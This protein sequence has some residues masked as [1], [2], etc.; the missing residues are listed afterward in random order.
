SYAVTFTATNTLSGS[1]STA[2]TV[3][4]QN[5][6]PIVTAPATASVN[7]GSLLT[8]VVSATDADGDDVTLSA[9]ILPLGAS[10]TDGG[11]GSNTGTFNW[12]PGFNQAGPYSVTFNGSDGNGGSGSA[13]TSITVNNVNRAPTANANGPY[14]GVIGINVAFSSAGSSDPD[15]DA[16]TYAWDFGD[17]ATSTQANPNH[18]YA[19]AGTYDVTLTV[20]EASTPDH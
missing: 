4:N 17:L 3:G 10:F 11:A 5:Q 18:A 7:E 1:A 14:T 16:L 2:I 20:T 19:A 6:N 12:T 13:S 15:G 8:F 9:P